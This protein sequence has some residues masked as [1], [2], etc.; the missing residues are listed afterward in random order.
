MVA[1]LCC[2]GIRLVVLVII[3]IV[4]VSFLVSL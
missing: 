4:P 3:S 1:K 2:V